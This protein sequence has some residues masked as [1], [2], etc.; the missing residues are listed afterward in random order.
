MDQN[1]YLTTDQVPLQVRVEFVTAQDTGCQADHCAD[2]CCF[3]Q[4]KG[5]PLD[6][7]DQRCV[8]GQGHYRMVEVISWQR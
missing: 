7:G 6:E 4:M 3:N 5:C 8:L 2:L 1:V